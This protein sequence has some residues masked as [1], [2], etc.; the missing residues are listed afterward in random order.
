MAGIVGIER[1]ND[2]RWVERTL[3]RIDH[4][5]GSGKV[6]LQLAAATLGEVWPV[7][8]ES[9]ALGLEEHGVVLDG[10][11]H[12]WG[13][14]GPEAMSPAG[15]LAAAYRE[16]GPEFVSRLEGP[17]ALAIAA[18]EGLFLA[19]DRV[20][21]SP[22]YW[23][24]YK[25]ALCFASEMKALL[26]RG[27]EV[28]E[29]PPGHY[30]HPGRGLVRYAEFRLGE[31]LEAP[32]EEVTKELRGLLEESVA[33]RVRVSE[34]G[35]WLSGGI[36]SATMTALA[37]RHVPKLAT[38]AVGVEGAPDLEY[39]RVTAEYLDTEH[40]E[41]VC[42]VGEMLEALPEVIYHLESFDALLV[43]SSV[44]NY[45]V[46]RLAAEHVPAVLS[47]EGGDE[48]F[49]GYS[50]LGELDLSAL[51][52]EL[53][54]ITGRLHNTALQRVDRCSASHGLVARTGFLDDAVVDYALRIPP[55]MKVRGAGRPVH[56]WILRR[57]VEDL[58][59]A[60]VVNRKKAKFWEGAGVSTVLAAH[61]EGMLSD[62]E[63]T[64]ERELAGGVTL[65]TKE[66]MMYYKVFREVFGEEADPGQVGRTKGAPVAAA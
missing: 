37:C 1:A 4:R 57:A 31:M 42:D 63:F 36:D 44:T 56:K 32:A 49:G 15:A 54:E 26:A 40:H 5:G 48:L 6:V 17:F 19:R 64:S 45:L 61:A 65:N 47:G 55:E 23:G 14:L 43:R 35:A 9:F 66:E 46:G 62:A 8:H 60:V 51:P 10:E 52:A 22:L 2:T 27:V 41:R 28:T 30:Y 39:A 11:I 58:L 7:G 53:L 33:K 18:E 38:F 50:Y 21:K 3:G 25:G 29:F 13:S 24:T 20:G 12:N 16:S 34:V 59:P